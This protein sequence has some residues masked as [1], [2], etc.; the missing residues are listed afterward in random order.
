MSYYFALCGENRRIMWIFFIFL[1]SAASAELTDSLEKDFLAWAND[2]E[3]SLSELQAITGENVLHNKIKL[4]AEEAYR[5]RTHREP[6]GCYLRAKAIAL[7]P[8][9][10]SPNSTQNCSDKLFLDMERNALFENTYVSLN[11]SVAHVPT[12]VYDLSKTIV[13][14]GNWTGALD[15]VFRENA[16][17]DPTLKWQY[18]GSSTGFFQFYPGSMWEVQLD[19]LRLDFFDCRSQPWYLSASSY[20]KEMLILVDKSGSMK[21]RSDIIS[22]ATV[23]EILNTLTENDFFNIIMFT[24][25]PRYADPAIQDR[26]IQ[27]FKYNKDRMVRRFQNFNPNGTAHYERALTEAFSLMNKTREN[28]TNS[29]HCSQMLM[30]ITD[31]VPDSYKEL[32]EKLDPDKNVRIFVYLLGQHSYAE[33]Y[34]EELACLNRGYAV[35][36]ATLADVKENVLKYL[37]VVARSNA[38]LNHGFITWSGVT[39]QQFN[40]KRLTPDNFTM[41]FITPAY[42][43]R[44]MHSEPS[45]SASDIKL[46][47]PK[48]DT[49]IALKEEEPVMYTSVAEAVYDRTKKA[50][51]LKQGNLLGVAGI[52]V[53]LQSFRDALR[54][55][56]AGV[57]NYLFAVDNNGFVLFH[58]GYRP[59]YKSTLKSHY[60]NVDLNEVEVPQ[61]VK[62]DPNTGTPDY[63]TPLRETMIERERKTNELPAQIVT[64]NFHT[65]FQA[66]RKYFSTPLEQTP[67]TLGL[68]VQWNAETG[69]GDPIPEFVGARAMANEEV[70]R[71]DMDRFAPIYAEDTGSDCSAIHNHSHQGATLSPYQFC[72]F[73]QALAALWQA[74]PICALRRILLDGELQ[75]RMMCDMDYLLQIRLDA[76]ETQPLQKFWTQVHSSPLISKWGVQQAFSFHHSGLIRFHNF[77]SPVYPNFIKDHIFGVEDPLYA[78]T[79]LTNQYF[80]AQKLTVFH[81]PP[82][83]RKFSLKPSCYWFL[84]DSRLI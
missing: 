13:S 63:A 12:N 37:N 78:E 59:V 45:D 14:V 44:S 68:A 54:G 2:L 1:C 38:I 19:E 69:R 39:V 8:S 15:A 21:G 40:L 47:E 61:D 6:T 71:S 36:I 46:E 51:R 41:Q 48:I 53:P 76:K 11:Y 32:L 80:H 62:I 50:M 66:T 31:S 70:K 57:N 20:A 55:W 30:I 81:P 33:P 24:D 29:K 42:K 73:D 75:Q 9:I 17:S 26:L 23:T 22:N 35:T 34:V 43:L 49:M 74:D 25:T 56:Q 16:A 7:T 27:A 18:F 4:A 64:D 65:T 52:D 60:Q 28:Q 58:P 79:V 72:Q 3:K 84:V 83:D 82:N 10:L 67:F 77:S 5:T